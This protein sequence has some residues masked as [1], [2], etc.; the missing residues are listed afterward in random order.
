MFA[1]YP[2]S[3]FSVGRKREG[4][5]YFQDSKSIG[6]CIRLFLSMRLRLTR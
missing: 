2:F 3:V 6:R 4:I 5:G 1:A